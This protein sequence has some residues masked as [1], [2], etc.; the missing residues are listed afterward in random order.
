MMFKS[1]DNL[2]MR[3]TV[4][5]SIQEGYSKKDRTRHDAN[6]SD[7]RNEVAVTALNT[8]I[9]CST[10]LLLII[11]SGVPQCRLIK[12]RHTDTPT[13][14]HMNCFHLITLS[15]QHSK[16]SDSNSGTGCEQH[17][18]AD[19][20]RHSSTSPWLDARCVAV[21]YTASWSIGCSRSAS[22][23]RASHGGGSWVWCRR[24][25]SLCRWG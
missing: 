14:M 12:R 5:R 22:R 19:T 13:Q 21:A 15:Q 25:T 8:L 23:A 4:M 24:A 6:K 7:I 17:L 11:V 1:R 10:L 20:H 18:P 3:D 2:A 9:D 16:A